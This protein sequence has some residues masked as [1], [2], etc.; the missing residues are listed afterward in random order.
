MNS[1]P[2][3]R[4]DN[5]TQRRSRSS[6]AAAGER[7]A[8][9]WQL[10]LDLPPLSMQWWRYRGRLMTPSRHSN[11]VRLSH[12]RHH[13]RHRTTAHRI[14]RAG[15]K[16]GRQ[17]FGII[18]LVDSSNSSSVFWGIVMRHIGIRSRW[19]DHNVSQASASATNRA[20]HHKPA[21][22]RSRLA[23]F[24]NLTFRYFVLIP[25]GQQHRCPSFDV[26]PPVADKPGNGTCGRRRT[27]C[28][29]DSGR[30]TAPALDHS[31][32]N[33]DGRCAMRTV[34]LRP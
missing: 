12:L 5:S 2:K 16:V 29:S 27:G 6:R 34:P 14:R 22:L 8:W 28:S 20:R 33:A 31:R 7:G 23:R 30:A 32:E 11:R 26:A 13:R 17:I 19:R 10:D 18:D 9:G 21:R 25:T 24:Q 3:Q 1:P 4:I 15:I